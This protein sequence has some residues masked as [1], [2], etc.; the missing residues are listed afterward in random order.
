MHSDFRTLRGTSRDKKTGHRKPA[1]NPGRD[2]AGPGI[3]TRA[4]PGRTGHPPEGVSVPSGLKGEGDRCHEQAEGTEL[5]G[6]RAADP[7]TRH[8]AAHCAAA[9]LGLSQIELGAR[10]LNAEGLVGKW[11]SGMRKPTAFNLALWAE[12]LGARLRVHPDGHAIGL[13][14]SPARAGSG[15]W[16]RQDS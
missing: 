13:T 15:T 9:A 12:A 3:G 1:E 5:R 6:R 2:N 10:L 8:Q 4:G 14:P 7:A 11:E 16:I